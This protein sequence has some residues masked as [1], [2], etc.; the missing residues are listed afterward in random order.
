MS[1]VSPRTLTLLRVSDIDLL[2]SLLTKVAALL[3]GIRPEQLTLPT[4][5]TDF[6]VSALRGHILWAGEMFARAAGGEPGEGFRAD[7]AE[8]IRGWREQGTD[9]SVTIRVGQ[10]PGAMAVAMSIIEFST[11]GCDLAVATGQEIPFSDDELQRALTLAQA[12]VPDQFRGPGKAFGH[13]VDVPDTA[14]SAHRL[15]AFM[16]REVRA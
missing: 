4:P 9:R 14:A 2:E 11:H 8:M 1:T 12:T 16:G 7:A 5:C 15:L 6:D 13:Q 10:V 3:D